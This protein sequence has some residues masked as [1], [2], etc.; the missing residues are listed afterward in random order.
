LANQLLQL[1]GDDSQRR[2]ARAVTIRLTLMAAALL[3]TGGH[4][5]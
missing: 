4:L 2:S 5:R 3:A 1:S